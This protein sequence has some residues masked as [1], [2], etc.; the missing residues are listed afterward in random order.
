MKC[1]CGCG[2]KVRLQ[3][4]CANARARR[5]RKLVAEMEALSFSADPD[6]YRRAF[7][8]EGVSWRN[9]YVRVVHGELTREEIRPDALWMT[10]YSGA[11]PTVRQ[12]RHE[13]GRVAASP[14][15]EDVPDGAPSTASVVENALPAVEIAP[16]DELV[17]RIREVMSGRD[18]VT[19]GRMLG[20][21]AW[22]VNGNIACGSMGDDLVVR[23]A[24]CDRDRILAG[25]HV[26]S[27]TMGTRTM[28]GFVT[29]DS[30]A[31]ADHAELARWIDAA[32]GYAAW[33]PPR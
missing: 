5:A 31:I 26:R 15:H 12:A 14:R 2:R 25:A 28:R 8:F 16:S 20:I 4:R 18:G 27:M 33:P 22:M 1:S 9:Q 21:V 19:E 29:V 11:C 32:A 30:A 17:R 10:W 24:N 3:E 7:L 6:E 13:P 23:V